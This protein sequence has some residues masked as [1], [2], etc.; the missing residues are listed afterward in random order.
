MTAAFVHTPRKK[1]PLRCSFDSEAATAAAASKSRDVSNSTDGNSR[2]GSKAAVVQKAQ[3]IAC[4]LIIDWVHPDI[5]RRVSGQYG[6]SSFS[7]QQQAHQQQ[8]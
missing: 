4:T 6:N 8:H 1:L 7:E 3:T 2:R 5:S